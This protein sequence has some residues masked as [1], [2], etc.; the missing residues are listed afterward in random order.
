MG[1]QGPGVAQ[2]ATPGPCNP[3]DVAQQPRVSYLSFAKPSCIMGACSYASTVCVFREGGR[4]VAIQATV[5]PEDIEELLGL[6]RDKMDPLPLDVLLERY[7]ERL[8][9][10]AAK[11]AEAVPGNP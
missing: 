1:L 11:D 3:H 10:R 7:V 4:Q 6:L 9:E 2:S 8:K 5:E